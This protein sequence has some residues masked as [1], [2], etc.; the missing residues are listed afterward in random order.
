MRLEDPMDDRDL[1]ARDL[2]DRNVACL[3]PLIGRIREEEQVPTVEC[4][5]HRPTV[6]DKWTL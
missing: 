4:G 6:G 1:S 2:V 5:L 3:V